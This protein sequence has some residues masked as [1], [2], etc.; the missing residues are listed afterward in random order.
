[1]PINFTNQTSTGTT[2]VWKKG[3]LPFSPAQTATTLDL[4][5]LL[6]LISS[7]IHNYSVSYIEPD[8]EVTD[9]I[10]IE[11]YPEI[12]VIPIVPPIYV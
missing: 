2:F 10:T 11:I 9:E 3:G 6:P 5:T 4:N 12:R 7:G 8:A 1:L